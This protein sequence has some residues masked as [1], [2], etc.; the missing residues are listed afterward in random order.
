MT[1]RGPFQPLLFCDS[2]ILRCCPLKRREETL[3]KKVICSI[4]EKGNQGEKAETLLVIHGL[5]KPM[6][7]AETLCFIFQ[8]RNCRP[9]HV[10]FCYAHPEHLELWCFTAC[11][12][13][14]SQAMAVD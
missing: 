12:I 11:S 14:I 6:A 8:W 1:H 9:F 2:V 10:S 13:F 3:E 4:T 7:K 5:T